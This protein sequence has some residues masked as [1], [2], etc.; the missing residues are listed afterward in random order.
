[1]RDDAVQLLRAEGRYAVGRGAV[2]WMRL[3][4]ILLASGLVYGAVMGALGGRALGA[5]YSCIKLP[6]LLCF[7]LLACLPN[8]Y[9]MNAVLG[10]RHDFAAAVRGILS[11][12]GTLALALVALAPVTAFFYVCGLTYPVAL[13]WNGAAF[14]LALVCA[15]V[16]LARHYRPLIA[17][18]RR[19]RLALLAWFALYAFVS[20][21]VGWV[22]R[23]F[24]GDPALPLE[25][26]RAGKWQENPYMNLFWTLAGFAWSVLRKLIGEG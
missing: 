24:V 25:F 5:M 15:Q 14:A 9:A 10:L 26:L 12:Q 17:R 23:P 6:I 4:A 2:P 21:K 16:T 3:A 18:D 8:F 22:L 19:H 13:L 1:M 20:I 7:S 11:A